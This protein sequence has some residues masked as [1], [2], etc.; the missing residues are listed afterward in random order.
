MYPTTKSC[1]D[2]EEHHAVVRCSSRR[3]YEVGAKVLDSIPEAV[4]VH[5]LV[6]FGSL[7]RIMA[8]CDALV[9]DEGSGGALHSPHDDS[10]CH[11]LHCTAHQHLLCHAGSILRIIEAKHRFPF[12][13]PQSSAGLFTYMGRSRGPQGQVSCEQFAQ[14]QL[15][16]LVMDVDTCDLISYSLGSSK[17]FRIRRDNKWLAMAL[18]ILAHMSSTY[19]QP[20]KQP[21]ADALMDDKAAL[22]KSFVATTKATMHR[23][24]R[25][26]V[27]DVKSTVNQAAMQ[28]Y[29]LDGVAP[30][31]KNRQSVGEEKH[32]PGTVP[33]C[34]KIVR[35]ISERCMHLQ[36]TYSPQ[37]GRVRVAPQRLPLL[38]RRAQPQEKPLRRPQLLHLAATLEWG[39]PFL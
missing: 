30:H 7:P 19:M 20:G 39:Q 26:P 21:K 3:V 27:L 31:D 12:V 1:H 34:H 22:H 6:G 15:Q 5:T 37:R 9:K 14:C 16:M 23:L 36:R 38:M 18:E 10:S 33:C 8:S 32:S 11:C 29:F 25:Q 13:M 2:P 24:A 4:Q 17:I 28:P 35:E